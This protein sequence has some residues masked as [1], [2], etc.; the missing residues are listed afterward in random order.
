MP[1]E[2]YVL[3]ADV[4]AML[5]A[6]TAV[7]QNQTK[8]MTELQKTKKHLDENR[9]AM[10]QMG[11]QF[12]TDLLAMGTGFVTLQAALSGV[13]AVIREVREEQ[14]K[15]AEEA[16]EFAKGV[17]PFAALGPGGVKAAGAAARDLQKRGVPLAEGFNAEMIIRTELVGDAAQ[18]A[19]RSTTERLR[20]PTGLGMNVLANAL[21][22][23]TD[24]GL[25][26]EQSGAA[27]LFLRQRGQGGLAELLSGGAQAV[28]A[29]AQFGVEPG[30]AFGV[31]TALSTMPGGSPGGAQSAMQAIMAAS[32]KKGKEFAKYGIRGTTAWERMRGLGEAAAAGDIGE[33]EIGQMVGGRGMLASAAFLG[34]NWKQVEALRGQFA[35]GMARP[36]AAITAAEAE[37]LTT[38][39]TRYAAA[40]E[41]AGGRVTGKR[42]DVAGRAGM[43]REL[44]GAYAEEERMELFQTGLG[45]ALN[46][47]ADTLARWMP[48]YGTT[49]ERRALD[50]IEGREPPIV[51]GRRPVQTT[52]MP[53]EGQ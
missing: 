18:Q 32:V 33:E 10:S 37:Y 11:K 41:R 49:A 52:A 19:M 26:A 35:Q 44:A 1:T 42:A 2:K 31:Y 47:F 46:K 14:R 3:E 5:S 22:E 21:T 53:I 9:D 51:T 24:V 40:I 28:G 45:R 16:K 30:Q 7:I 38:P 12:T 23:Y 48:G 4:K 20:R 34:R 15:A 6:Q 43:I 36:G 13:K 27:A 39:E 50:T 25:S 29:A 8:L 17:G